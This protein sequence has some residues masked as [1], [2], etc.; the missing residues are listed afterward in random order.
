MSDF[1]YISDYFNLPSYQ[2]TKEFNSFNT[3]S[4]LVERKLNGCGSVVVSIGDCGS[5]GPGSIP[6]R[7][8]KPFTKRFAKNRNC[9]A[10]AITNSLSDLLHRP[11]KE[12]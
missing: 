2:N 12:N 1:I 3:N 6:G 9:E 11:K 5:P 10:V 8:P 7:G 4:S